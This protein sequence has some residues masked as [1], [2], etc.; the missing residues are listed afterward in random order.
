MHFSVSASLTPV[1]AEQVT[2]EDLT[3]GNFTGVLGLACESEYF[4]ERV[5]LPS[6]LMLTH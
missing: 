6:V 5:H 3:G 2:D 4:P 1:A